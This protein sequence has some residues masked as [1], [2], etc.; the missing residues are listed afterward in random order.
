VVPLRRGWRFLVQREGCI[1]NRIAKSGYDAGERLDSWED[2]M[3][4]QESGVVAVS[5]EKISGKSMR[6]VIAGIFGIASVDNEIC[7]ELA[8]AVKNN[9][10]DGLV[11]CHLRQ[12]FKNYRDVEIRAG[13][14]VLTATV[15]AIIGLA[16]LIWTIALNRGSVEVISAA[17][18]Q[19]TSGTIFVIYAWTLREFSFFHINLERTC[20]YLLAYIIAQKNCKGDQTLSELVCIMAR[21]PIISQRQVLIDTGKIAGIPHA[22][23]TAADPAT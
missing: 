12:S 2:E 15:F 18:V 22:A 23:P 11:I 13:L 17:M 16:V 4:D 5:G 14:S 1:S 3:A 8:D 9:H 19:V 10:I 6:A 7:K 20:R 21:A